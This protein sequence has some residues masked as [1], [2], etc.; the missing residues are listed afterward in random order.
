MILIF[1]HFLLPFF[2][3]LPVKAKTD[4]KIML[5]V[6]AWA[7]AMNF[8]DLSFNILPTL[9]PHGY[10]FQMALAATR[11]P[12]FHGRIFKLGFPEKF[13]S[14]CAVPA[15][16]PAPARSHGKP[17]HRAGRDFRRASNPRRGQ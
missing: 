13:Q 5:P 8:L 2:V 9:H 15:K 1:G 4:F 11:L 12:R 6:C 10:P 16:R 7:L 17:V 3:L 14:S